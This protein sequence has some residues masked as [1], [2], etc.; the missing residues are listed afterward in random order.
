MLEPVGRNTAPA[1]AA[2]A[3]QLAARD[4]DALMLLLPSDHVIA[5]TAAFLAAVDRAAARPPMAGW[6]PSA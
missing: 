5:D 1:A 4:P 3:L 6:S 2:A